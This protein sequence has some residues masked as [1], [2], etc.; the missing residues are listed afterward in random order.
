MIEFIGKAIEVAEKAVEKAIEIREAAKAQD[1][2]AISKFEYAST[3]FKEGLSDEALKARVEA[4]AHSACKFFEIP[5]ADLIEGDA[6]GVYREC[7]IFLDKDVFEYSLDQFKDMKCVSFEDM[8]KVWAHEC[9]H[10]ILRMDFPSAWA[11][12]L[13]ADF[14][15]GVRS[16][17]L[18]LPTS[19]FEKVLGST[20]GS[21]THPVG[22]LRVQAIQFGREVV[23]GFQEKGITPTIEN[24]KEAFA[25]SP[26]SEITYENYS[27]PQFTK[28][29]DEKGH[30]K[31]KLKLDDSGKTYSQNGELVP[32][33]EYRL[34]GYTYRTDEVGRITQVEGKI[35]LPPEK[36]DRDNLP[37]IKDKRETDH[38]GHLIAHELG[39]ADT[40]GNL[41]SMD[42]KLNQG[43]YRKMENEIKRSVEEGKDVRVN[44][45][46][47]YRDDSHRPSSFNM[48]I[49]I[50]GEHTE[51]VFINESKQ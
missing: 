4:A 47:E 10:R 49:D 12:E 48:S 29:V 19:N 20:T 16:E 13:G 39:G 31:I 5:D 44:I 22:S 36:V 18:G 43:D 15:S 34:N 6:I 17:M 8:T 1:V 14:F 40:E 23:R 7:D 11:Q 38:K 32:N 24:C 35:Q 28:F 27:T 41:V 9:G 37:E 21:A 51:K 42:G 45:E 46:A 50:D 30:F 2:S 25:K 26:F 33:N 3:Q